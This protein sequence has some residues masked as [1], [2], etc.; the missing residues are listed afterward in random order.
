MKIKLFA[1]NDHLA[2]EEKINNFI[3]DKT[4]FDIKYDS[5]LF[6]SSYNTQTGIPKDIVVNDR[7]LILYEEK[8]PDELKDIYIKWF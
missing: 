1:D 6:H 7:V 3:K 4:V 2:L 5:N 8:D